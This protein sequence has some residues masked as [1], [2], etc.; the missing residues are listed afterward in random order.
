MGSQA[1]LVARTRIIL[2][3]CARTI[4]NIFIFILIFILRKYTERN[5]FR[6]LFR[7]ATQSLFID[8]AENRGLP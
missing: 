1:Q 3:T 7:L 2:Q 8:C 6:A 5:A 4:A